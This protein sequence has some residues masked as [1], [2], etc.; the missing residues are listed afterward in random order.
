VL[1]LA[2]YTVYLVASLI[3]RSFE[4]NTPRP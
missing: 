3:L 4:R 2:A 1:V